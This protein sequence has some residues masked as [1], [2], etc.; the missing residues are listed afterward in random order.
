MSLQDE[1]ESSDEEGGGESGGDEGA[2]AGVNVV[3]FLEGKRSQRGESSMSIAALV[4]Q[5]VEDTVL[6]TGTC[7]FTVPSFPFKLL[8]DSAG[9]NEPF[10][11]SMFCVRS[12][13][14]TRD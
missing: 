12:Q 3:T 6:Q 1:E 8:G 11:N 13:Q 7:G 14:N 5:Q 2:G 9:G 10:S 4:L